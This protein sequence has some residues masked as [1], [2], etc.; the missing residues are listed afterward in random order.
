MSSRSSSPRRPTARWSN[1]G[2]V[3]AAALGLA[4]ILL[5]PAHAAPTFYRDVLPILQAHCQECHR[6]GEAAPIPFVT[7]AQV[8]PWA[9]AIRTAVVTRKMPPWFADPCCGK[10]SNDRSLSIAERETLANWADSGAAQGDARDAPPPRS[11]A[12]GWNLPAPPDK[13]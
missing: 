8:R 5:A 6:P 2:A 4:L 9:K 12:G 11:F 13:V 7:Y 3:P 10:F 1:V